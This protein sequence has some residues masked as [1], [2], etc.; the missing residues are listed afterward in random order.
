MTSKHTYTCIPFVYFFLLEYWFDFI[1]FHF[2][3]FNFAVKLDKIINSLVFDP[4]FKCVNIIKILC[5]C[6][7]MCLLYFLFLINWLMKKFR[8]VWWTHLYWINLNIRHYWK[9]YVLSSSA[10]F[11]MRLRPHEWRMWKGKYKSKLN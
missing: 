8:F 7:S 11:E 9:S 1:H 3:M 2:W 5:M 6:V 10:V 4:F